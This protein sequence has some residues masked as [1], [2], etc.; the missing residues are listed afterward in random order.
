[1]LNRFTVCVCG[2]VGVAGGNPLISIRKAKRHVSADFG[3]RSQDGPGAKAASF[4]SCGASTVGLKQTGS[5]HKDKGVTCIHW[6]LGQVFRYALFI[7]LSV[8]LRT[9]IF[10]TAGGVII[11]AKACNVFNLSRQQRCFVCFL[12]LGWGRECLSCAHSL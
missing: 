12:R 1:M 7:N 3:H 4:H 11:Q 2:G 6:N 10:T 9:G 5:A 8:S